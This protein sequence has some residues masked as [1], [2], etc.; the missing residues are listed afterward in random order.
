[1]IFLNIKNTRLEFKGA[2]PLCFANYNKLCKYIIFLQLT[3]SNYG[4]R[5]FVKLKF[6]YALKNIY[7]I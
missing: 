7:I 2:Q 3:I 6:Y 5:E 4:T 1:M